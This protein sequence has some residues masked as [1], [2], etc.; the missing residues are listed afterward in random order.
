MS[1]PSP[2]PSPVIAGIEVRPLR[3]I[4]DP[5]GSFVETYRR[6]EMPSGAREV[7]QSNISRSKAGVLRGIHY[8]RAQ[9]DYWVVLEGRA[10]VAL[11]DLRPG[12]PT[13]G[14]RQELELDGAE[15]SGLYIPRMVAHGFYARTDLVLQYMVDAYYDGGRDEHGIAW[16][17]PD[18]QIGWP[19]PD[20][21][22]SDRDRSNP[23]LAQA[24]AEDPPPA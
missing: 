24:L 2:D 3:P 4:V 9:S 5:R 7:V 13:R 15:P 8:H 11:L 20:P 17:D 12:S 1:E 22:L 16:N 14:G 19:D 23:P 10:F 18:A 6:T 21:I